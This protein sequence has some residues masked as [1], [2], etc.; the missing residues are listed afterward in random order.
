MLVMR[1]RESTLPFTLRSHSSRRERRCPRCGD[2]ATGTDRGETERDQHNRRVNPAND[3]GPQTP[4]PKG[5]A[6]AKAKATD[7]PVVDGERRVA[8]R[9]TGRRRGSGPNFR[10]TPGPDTPGWQD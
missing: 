9:R 5:K 6:K 10:R 1:A 2:I 3:P 7:E 8:D 4:E